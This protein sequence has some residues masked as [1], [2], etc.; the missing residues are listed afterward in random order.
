MDLANLLQLLALVSEVSELRP[1]KIRVSEH[2]LLRQLDLE[3]LGLQHQ[4]QLQPLEV[5]ELLQQL[6]IPVLG[7]LGQ[8]QHK[9]AL[10]DL[11]QPPQ[12][13]VLEDL[14]PVSAMLE[15]E[16][17]DL[18]VLGLLSNSSSSKFNNNRLEE[19]VMLTLLY[20]SQ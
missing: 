3:A 17:L 1:L 10:E 14:E 20:I 15:E 12:L 16:T 4:L 11:G 18:V 7:L 6:K 19:L 2:L 13:T 5:L 8:K 9:Q